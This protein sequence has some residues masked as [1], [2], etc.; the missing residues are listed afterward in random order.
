MGVGSY[1]VVESVLAGESIV[2]VG[3]GVWASGGE[4]VY[5]EVGVGVD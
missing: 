4:L 2:V 1:F 5:V 3:L